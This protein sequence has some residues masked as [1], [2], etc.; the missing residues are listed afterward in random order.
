[1]AKRQP[2]PKP[3]PT[4][5]LPDT[6]EGGTITIQRELYPVHAAM[7]DSATMARMIARD[8]AERMKAKV[9]QQQRR[10]DTI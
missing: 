7:P 10:R 3:R 8:K 9:R 1:M 4:E 5:A 6:A 2:I